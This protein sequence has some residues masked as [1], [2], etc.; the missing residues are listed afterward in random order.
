MIVIKIDDGT[1]YIKSGAV[2]PQRMNF[3]WLFSMLNDIFVQIEAGNI[4]HF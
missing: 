4:M 3:Y 1:L 2:R